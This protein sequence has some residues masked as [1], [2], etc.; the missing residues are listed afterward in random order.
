MRFAFDK[1]DNFL[2]TLLSLV[3]TCC[4]IRGQI[5]QTNTNFDPLIIK[6]KFLL[7]KMFSHNLHFELFFEFSLIM[8]PCI[9]IGD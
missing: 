8:N 7:S 4:K 1:E 9:P 2:E 6:G 3:E 5:N